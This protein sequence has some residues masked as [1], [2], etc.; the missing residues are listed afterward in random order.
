MR[1]IFSNRYRNCILYSQ[2]N[3]RG[4]PCTKKARIT[5]PFSCLYLSEIN[6]R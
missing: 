5:A 6:A 2:M 1:G 4:M 3:D